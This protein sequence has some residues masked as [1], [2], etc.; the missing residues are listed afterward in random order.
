[1]PDDHPTHPPARTEE[2]SIPIGSPQWY[3]MC[4]DRLK[5]LADPQRLQIV[6][7]LIAGPKFV[8]D[9]AQA[10]GHPIVRVSHHLSVMRHA[11]LVT[12]TKQ[13][14]FVAYALHPD[15]FDG[16]QTNGTEYAITIG[17]CRLLLPVPTP[18][19]DG[20]KRTTDLS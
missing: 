11:K 17:R 19:S 12:D 1:M 5:A 18:G 4:A 3:E 13:G 15:V 9:L 8:G 20:E 10:L 7:Q 6:T 2:H 16:S 14:R